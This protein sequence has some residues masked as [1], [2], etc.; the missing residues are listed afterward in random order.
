MTSSSQSH[1]LT[2]SSSQLSSSSQTTLAP[3]S[4]ETGNLVS[5]LSRQMWQEKKTNQRVKYVNSTLISTLPAPLWWW[6][7]IFL[8][9]GIFYMTTAWHTN[10]LFDIY[11]EE[12]N[13][14]LEHNICVIMFHTGYASLVNKL[15]R[16]LWETK[17][18]NPTWQISSHWP[19]EDCLIWSKQVAT[20]CVVC[21]SV[22][23]TQYYHS[24]VWRYPITTHTTLYS[25]LIINGTYVNIYHFSLTYCV[26]DA[27]SS[28]V[29]IIS[30][31]CSPDS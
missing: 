1:D 14:V 3:P 23:I 17:C 5:V 4:R 25:I 7:H 18:F 9:L 28:T 29:L 22:I 21:G 10:S 24:T 19:G 31:F 2:R 12:A 11:K 16:I 13:L 26:S 15:S 6:Q 8:R 20:V 30:H 27:S